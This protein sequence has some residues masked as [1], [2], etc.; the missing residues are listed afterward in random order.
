MNDEE[1]KLIMALNTQIS[2]HLDAMALLQEEIASLDGRYFTLNER[3]LNELEGLLA[4]VQ[5]QEKKVAKIRKLI[6]DIKSKA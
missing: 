4:A 5:A 1:R 6:L 2:G 3:D